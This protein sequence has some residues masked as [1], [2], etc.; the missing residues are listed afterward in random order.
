LL[1]CHSGLFRLIAAAVAGLVTLRLVVRG[2]NQWCSASSFSCSV[3]T[4]LLG[5]VL[6]G[7]L[8][9]CRYGFWRALL[10]TRHRRTVLARLDRQA[11]ADGHPAPGDRER[12]AIVAMVLAPYRNWSRQPPMTVVA[13]LGDHQAGRDR[14]GAVW[15]KDHAGATERART[16]GSRVQ[17]AAA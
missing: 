6:V 16:G 1:R 17:S 12:E 4:N 9:N 10:L 5:V 7:E 15:S 2:S 11:Q 14:D 8:I 13:G 3:D